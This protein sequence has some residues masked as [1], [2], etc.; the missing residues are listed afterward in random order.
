MNMRF[1]W[2]TLYVK[3]M[4]ESLKFYEEVVGLQLNRISKMSPT[5]ELAFLGSDATQVELIYDES[6]EIDYKNSTISLGF[7]TES[8]EVLIEQFNQK[9]IA[10][11][12]GPIQPNPNLRFF[13]ILDPN[14]IKIQ[15]IEFLN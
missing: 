10:I 3:N 9:G 7:Q 14:G 13:Y 4:D 8:L 12:A 5:F 15:F 1:C 6:K 11:L 2:T